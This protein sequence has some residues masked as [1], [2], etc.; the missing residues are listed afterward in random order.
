MSLNGGGGAAILAAAA[1][2]GGA[3]Q[4]GDP[5]GPPADGVWQPVAG[6]RFKFFVYSAF[7]DTRLEPMVSPPHLIAKSKLLFVFCY[8]CLFNRSFFFIQVKEWNKELMKIWEKTS[9]ALEKTEA[10]KKQE[11]LIH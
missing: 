9:S 1:A 11:K 4:L 8:N 5:V 6:T 10:P 2:A 7:L 3:D